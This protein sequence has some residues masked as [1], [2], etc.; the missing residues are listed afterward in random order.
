MHLKY[1]VSYRCTL[2]AALR[3]ASS[4]RENSCQQAATDNATADQPAASYGVGEPSQQT[5]ATDATP[6]S[7][8]SV[9]QGDIVQQ[10]STE[11]A[12]VRSS[13][14]T[15]PVDN[16][17]Q[18][19]TDASPSSS[20]ASVDSGDTK[21]QAS[22]DAA[23]FMSPA[24]C[25]NRHSS[26]LI[27]RGKPCDDHVSGTDAM[28]LGNSTACSCST[29]PMA[30]TKAPLPAAQHT[31]QQPVYKQQPLVSSQQQPTMAAQQESL[32]S[33]EQ[34]LL[35]SHDQH[36]LSSLK[37]VSLSSQEQWARAASDSVKLQ[38]PDKLC[39]LHQVPQ[40]LPSITHEADQPTQ[41]FVSHPI[42]A[43]EA[44]HCRAA[45]IQSIN[46]SQQL[47]SSES[48]TNLTRAVQADRVRHWSIVE[49]LLQLHQPWPACD[50][51][52]LASKAGTVPALAQTGLSCA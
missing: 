50:F 44:N 11:A 16:G 14:S 42:N 5:L 19:S 47:D 29:A 30:D 10:V 4:D 32:S 7:T 48:T 24:D 15:C 35:P 9:D 28:D 8:A 46:V 39:R 21:Q 13:A 2:Q 27:G 38:Q 3:A 45:N 34:Q 36:L 17:E 26:A 51:E 31:I 41:S 23:P 6:V 49:A 52:A 37:Q 40:D 1:C 22:T 33:Q 25:D 12:I 18:A 43:E 20:A